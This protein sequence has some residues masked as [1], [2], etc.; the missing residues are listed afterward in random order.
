MSAIELRKDLVKGPIGVLMGGLSAERDISLVSGRAALEVLRATG[1]DVLAIDP[2]ES[3]MVDKMRELKVAHTFIALHGPGGED[4]TVQ[5]FLE[6][7]GISYTG[8]GVLASALAMDKLHCKQLWHGINLPT[9]E[10]VQLSG[11]THWQQV[12]DS[13]G[14][15][16]I[17]KPVHEGSSIGMSRVESADALKAAY[18]TAKIY[19]DVVIAERWIDGGEYTVAILGED[20]LPTIKLETDNPFYDYE[21]KY[22]A[23]DTRYICPCELSQEE[24]TQIDFLAL[25]AFR[26]LG[27]R[28]WG[29]VDFMRDGEGNWE[30][31][32]VNTVPGLTSHSLVPMAAKAQG[33]SFSDLIISI[34]NQ[35]LL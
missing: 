23:N 22:L 28:H 1:V 29:R 19:D 25:R 30:I 34:M 16:L 31:L 17:V 21:A 18:E 9:P 14:P 6:T 11:S 8:S 4:G 20:T 3:A 12:L 35:S 5:G 26:S 27:C 24:Q 32:E 13:I 15:Q 7:L 33:L 10:Y 2:C